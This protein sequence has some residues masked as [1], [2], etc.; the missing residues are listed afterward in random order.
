M[1]ARK[2]KAT[3]V[4]GNIRSMFLQNLKPAVRKELAH[5]SESKEEDSTQK[6]KRAAMKTMLLMKIAAVKTKGTN[7]ALLKLKSKTRP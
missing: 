2:R 3:I 5:V 7:R 4:V 1:L 6:M